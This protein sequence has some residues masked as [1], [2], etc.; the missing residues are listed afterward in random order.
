MSKLYKCD[1]FSGDGTEID[2][3]VVTFILYYM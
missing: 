2:Y 1:D 3:E